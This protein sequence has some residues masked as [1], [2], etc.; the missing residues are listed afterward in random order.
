MKNHSSQHSIESAFWNRAHELETLRVWYAQEPRLGVIHGR[1]R[2]GKTSLL[3][4]WLKPTPGAYVQATEGTPAAQRA[5]L[6]EDLQPLLPGF[7]EAA[8]PTW[9][10]LLDALK[11]QWPA[12]GTA[13]NS[14]EV[15]GGPPV[16]VLDEFPYLAQSAPE[17]PSVLQAMV[18][19]PD[20]RRLPIVIC[21]SSQRMMQGLVLNSAA[22]LYGRAQLL[23]RLQPL[24]AT[25]IRAAL[26]LP[27]AIGAVEVYAAFGGVPRYWELMREGGY[28]TAEEALDHLVF[29][30][31]G[32]LHEEAERVLRD[33]EAATLERA[34]CELI[35]RGAHRPSELAAR[36]G[37][38][39]TTLAKPLRH[40]VDLGLI[41]RQAP[42]DLESGRSAVG[43]RRA[44]YRLQDPFLAMWYACVRPYLSGLNLS[45]ATARQ[46]AREAWTHHVAA[47]WEDL[48]RQQWHRIGQPTV[49]WEPAGRYWASRESTGAEWDVV[50]VSSDRKHMFLGECK[51]MRDATR[52]KVDAAVRT[53]KRRAIPPLPEHAEVHMG[54]FIPE[55]AKLPPEIEGVALFDA[56]HVM[57]S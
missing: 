34:V 6:A 3:R 24:P 10:A 18:D 30:P 43:G 1:R 42:Y 25:E 45:A 49:D 46:H 55:R 56:R 9:R 32:V 13:P 41:E 53:I 19:A 15:P 48:C 27:D 44:L 50:S 51:W 35:G 31:Q 57:E 47:V 11:R 36:L 22:P 21:G 52:A 8:Y 28:A 17:L 26:S 39:D 7:G 54:L 23:L 20:A 2:L 4:R 38:K 40:L 16:L 29:S 5:A 37:V 33:E 14:A 12:R